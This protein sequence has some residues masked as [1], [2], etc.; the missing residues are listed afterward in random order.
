MEFW[1]RP[2]VIDEKFSS[3]ISDTEQKIQKKALFTVYLY[4][5]TFF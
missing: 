2:S 1:K 4:A 3:R 5:L